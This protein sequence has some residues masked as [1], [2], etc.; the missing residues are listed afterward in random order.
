[1]NIWYHV[2]LPNHRAT[3]LINFNGKDVDDFA[4]AI[5]AANPEGITCD[6][7]ALVLLVARPDIESNDVL[8]D[9]LLE[10]HGDFRNLIQHYKILR[11]NPIKVKLPPS[12]HSQETISTPSPGK[13]FKVILPFIIQCCE[14]ASNTLLDQ[15]DYILSAM[16]PSKHSRVGLPHSKP[17]MWSRISR[18]TTPTPIPG[19]VTEATGRRAL[20]ISHNKIY[21]LHLTRKEVDLHKQLLVVGV[22]VACETALHG[23]NRFPEQTEQD[24]VS[25]NI[26]GAIPRHRRFNNDD[27]SEC[28]SSVMVL[29]RKATINYTILNNS[30]SA[31]TMTDSSYIPSSPNSDISE[32]FI[33]TNEN[34]SINYFVGP[35][36]IEWS[37]DDCPSRWIIDEVDIS[38][39]CHEYRTAIIRKC[40]S[41]QVHLA[42]LEE[43]ALSHIFVFQ[44]ENMHDLYGYFDDNLWRNLFIEFRNLYPYASISDDVLHI[45][46]NIVK[47]VCENPN[48]QNR[49]AIVHGYLQS[50]RTTG[51]GEVMMEIIRNLADNE[52]S[53]FTRSHNIEDTHIHSNVAPMLRPFFKNRRTTII[54]W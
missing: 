13:F 26:P 42:A 2:E 25:G 44:E 50:L 17:N 1:M 45:F 19:K 35:G 30:P 32:E 5:K 10:Q 29:R 49:K 43:L 40:K 20:H 34:S 18:E 36:E 15:L 31:A 46:T 11:M 51:D 53:S 47:I 8:D 38:S 16:S 22:M 4:K 28:S 3:K 37:L 9:D 54:E 7:P 24:D 21:S 52:Q 6:P 14:Y 12:R 23:Y 39:I 48:Y 41:M 33:K 27:E